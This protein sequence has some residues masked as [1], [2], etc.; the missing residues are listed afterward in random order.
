MNKRQLKEKIEF[1][2][3]DYVGGKGEN[4]FEKCKDLEIEVHVDLSK[5]HPVRV[6]IK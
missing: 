1:A 5:R 4:C 6:E 3:L 2:V